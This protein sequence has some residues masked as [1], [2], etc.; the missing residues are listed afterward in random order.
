MSR[1][2]SFADAISEATCQALER[3]ASVFVMGVGVDDSG[4]IF[5]TTNEAYAR[6][7]DA[8]VFDTPISEQ[9]TT[10]AA[11][12]AAL[13][14]MRPILV[15]ARNDFLLLTLDQIANHAA[16]W[17]YMSGGRLKCPI[18]IRGIIGR[19]W[20]QAAQ[21]SQSL[22][23]VVAHFPGLHVL[24][25]SCAR[26]AKGLLLAALEGDTPTVIIEHRWSYGL[27]EEV[28]A[29]YFV[30]PIGKAR[31]A[32]VGADCT[33][34]AASFMVTEALRAAD[35]AAALGIDLE[36]IDL[37]T[38]RPWDVETVCASVRKTGRLIVADPGWGH[39]GLASEVSAVVAEREFSS[40]RAAV[41]R[42]ALPDVPTPC[43]PVLEAAYYPV[44][45]DVLRVARELC[46][47]ELAALQSH[48]VA[49]DATANGHA[50]PFA[51]AF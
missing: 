6:F 9:L 30:E 32:R 44:A 4:G 1:V 11:I 40:L 17:S 49:S 21:H 13:C 18:V 51:G 26:D 48:I 45:A 50:K 24:M 33:V 10:G 16:K 39:F 23:A 38:I 14:G 3:D 46:G 2:L 36:V 25:P 19:G 22:H 31:V 7:G 20:G 12:G 29:E 27:R 37:R 47:A 43:A 34:V 41:R 8:R 42:I 15:H 35:Q 28:P 5:G